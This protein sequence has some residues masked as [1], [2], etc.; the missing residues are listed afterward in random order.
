MPPALK[1]MKDFTRAVLSYFVSKSAFQA[2]FFKSLWII[3]ATGIRFP[4]VK[5]RNGERNT[6][7]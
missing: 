6:S 7:V 3:F 1:K 4:D 2:I 5:I